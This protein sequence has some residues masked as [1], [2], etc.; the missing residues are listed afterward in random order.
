VTPAAAALAAALGAAGALH[1]APAAFP[2]AEAPPARRVVVSDA[3]YAGWADPLTPAELLRLRLHHYQAGGAQALPA[4]LA[5]VLLP[6]TACGTGWL[7]LLA[8]DLTLRGGVEVFTAE[9]RGM[10]LQDRSRLDAL[11]RGEAAKAAG[12]AGYYLGSAGTPPAWKR[13]SKAEIPF[14]IMWGIR[15]IH[16]DIRLAV[17]RAR[18]LTGLPVALGG[19]SGGAV[20]ALGFAARRFEDGRA[21]HQE[22][23]GLVL[24]DGALLWNDDAQRERFTAGF[25]TWVEGLDLAEGFWDL[26]SDQIRAEIAAALALADPDGWSPLAESLVPPEVAGPGL[27]NRAFLGWCLDMGPAPARGPLGRLYQLRMGDLAPPPA[28]GT[29]TG[30]ADG[31]REGEPVRLA[32]AAAVARAPGGIFD[33]YHPA[34]LLREE[35][36]VYSGAFNHP[37]KGITELDA[38]GVPVFS[39]VTGSARVFG[40]EEP[41]LSGTWLFSRI[42]AAGSESVSVLEMAHADILLADA[43]K[44]KVFAPL[45]RWLMKAASS[46]GPERPGG[47]P[48]EGPKESDGPPEAATVSD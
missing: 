7:D 25:A 1:A 32:Q 18:E 47:A 40:P 33:W 17:R 43:A 5:L 31:G 44:E 24:L 9:R 3:A 16:E 19:F 8:R 34:A 35:S 30:W 46:A 4:R 39:V 27:T 28:P 20:N 41:P 36:E 6:C 10:G 45:H 15:A 23:A 12:A 48:A 42:R 11:L 14:V 21:G 13:P 22:I 29:L 37:E 38:V 26:R 2:A